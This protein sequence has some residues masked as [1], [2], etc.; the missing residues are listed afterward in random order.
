M[1]NIRPHFL[2]LF[3]GFALV[4]L[5]FGISQT[6]NAEDAPF[7]PDTANQ[8][9]EKTE[10]SPDD[11]TNRGISNFIPR[12]GMAAPAGTLTLTPTTTEPTGFKCS[13]NTGRCN[14]TGTADCKYM[15]DLIAT[16]CGKITCTGSGSSQKCNCTI[17][18]Y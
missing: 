13:P 11:V 2:T 12:A 10:S 4:G 1:K 14:C 9:I 6:A 8:E 5:I 17:N 15:K 7:P 16:S 18:G 3:L